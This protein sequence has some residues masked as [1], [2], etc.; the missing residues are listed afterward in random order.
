MATYEQLLP[1]YSTDQP[2][3]HGIVREMRKLLDQYNERM[4]I[5]EIYLPIHKLVTYYG[6]A[7][8]RGAH[9][10]FNFLLLSL[11]WKAPDISAAINEYE[12]ALPENGWPNWVLGNH[13]QSRLVSRI[14]LQQA[15]VAA[16]LL[17]TLH[18]TPTIYY[19]DEIGMADV[20]IPPEEIQDPQGLNMPDKNLSRDPQRTPMQWNNDTNAGFTE[21]KPWLR[22][23]AGYTGNNVQSQKQDPSSVLCFYKRLIE[24]R[25]Q[26][27]S[28][29]TGKYAPVFTDQQVIAFTRKTDN[30]D[31]F[32]I[33]LNLSHRPSYFSPPHFN[34]KGKVAVSTS[35]AWEDKG[36]DSGINLAGD[37]GMIIRLTD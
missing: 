15:R 34:M 35:P 21:A 26:E 29:M 16:I 14:G 8:E 30:A 9:L 17:L 25:Q 3:V 10:P 33:V 22:L 4:M 11:P 19:G 28:L 20:P 37:E 18:G 7:T 24:L 32:L 12:G 5:G 27:P 1:V 36:I 6:S 2:E 31:S 13:D 23:D